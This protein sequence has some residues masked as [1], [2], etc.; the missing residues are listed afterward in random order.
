MLTYKIHSTFSDY[1]NRSNSLIN[2]SNTHCF[3][4]GLIVEEFINIVD[5]VSALSDNLGMPL[6]QL[7]NHISYKN[8]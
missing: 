1:L 2:N 4:R 3:K 8:S 5:K 7:P 6:D